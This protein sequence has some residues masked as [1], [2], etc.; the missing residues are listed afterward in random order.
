MFFQNN[1]EEMDIS[2]DIHNSPRLNHEETKS[3][4]IMSKNQ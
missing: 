2:L 4:Q 1:V 3:D